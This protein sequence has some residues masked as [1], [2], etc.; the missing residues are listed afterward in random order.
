MFYTVLL[1]DKDGCEMA[2]TEEETL[3]DAKRAA[4]EYTKDREY[5]DAGAYKAV[6]L[7][8]NDVCVFDEFVE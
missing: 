8:S 4:I 1:L 7:D 2:R 6:V 5:I 3:R